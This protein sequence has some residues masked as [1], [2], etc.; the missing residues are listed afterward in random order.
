MY[1]LLNGTIDHKCA[2]LTLY[3]LQTASAN[4]KN[5]SLFKRSQEA[6]DEDRSNVSPLLAYYLGPSREDYSRV[7]R[8]L[9]EAEADLKNKTREIADL[10]QR[11]GMPCEEEDIAE[12]VWVEK[13][14]EAAATEPREERYPVSEDIHSAYAAQRSAGL[15]PGGPP[16]QTNVAL[17][18]SGASVQDSPSPSAASSEKNA[19]SLVIHAEEDQQSA[20]NQVRQLSAMRYVT[21]RLPS[22]YDGANCPT[23]ANTGLEWAT[24]ESPI[25]RWPDYPIPVPRVTA[26]TSRP[27]TI[28]S[29]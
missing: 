21:I 8:I 2:G 22:A 14:Y 20:V 13:M 25:T 12:P 3:A 6:D 24:I 7:F 19:Q 15:Q 28:E 10:K 23:Q 5:T 11:L 16:A 29:P 26:S 18:P 1:G 4:L 27:F 17:P 9:Q